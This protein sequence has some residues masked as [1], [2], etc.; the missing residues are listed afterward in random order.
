[1]AFQLLK[2][3]SSLDVTMLFLVYMEKIVCSNNYN[4]HE[5][6]REK[7]QLGG[8]GGATMKST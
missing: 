5:A 8:D 2:K 4:N 3:F 6:I 1:M 7:Y